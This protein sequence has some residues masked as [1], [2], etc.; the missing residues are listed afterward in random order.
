MDI[1]ERKER[2]TQLF[3]VLREEL[4]NGRIEAIG[5]GFYITISEKMANWLFGIFFF[6]YFPLISYNLSL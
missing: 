2:D 3:E 5:R 4:D 6:S 1:F